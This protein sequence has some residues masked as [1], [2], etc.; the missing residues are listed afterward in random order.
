[1]K[2]TETM[3]TIV[4]IIPRDNGG[5][6][7]LEAIPTRPPTLNG[8]CAERQGT[9]LR[10]TACACRMIVRGRRR[11]EAASVGAESYRTTGIPDGPG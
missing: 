6:A 2:L 3:D 4:N 5:L 9:P 10:G 7:T 8:R 1:M 11:S